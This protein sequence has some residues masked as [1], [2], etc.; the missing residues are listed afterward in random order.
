MEVEA[1]LRAAM[2]GYEGPDW[3]ERAC[4]LIQTHIAMIQRRKEWDC[5]TIG[6]RIR[7]AREIAGMSQEQL[8]LRLDVTQLELSGWERGKRDLPVRKLR[9]LAVSMGVSVEWLL[10]ES[11]EGGPKVKNGLLRRNLPLKL[12]RYMRKKGQINAARA[13]AARINALR[14]KSL[15]EVAALPNNIRRKTKKRSHSRS[16]TK[17]SEEPAP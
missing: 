12:V 2:D 4:E 5:S 8:A 10:M 14:Q 16:R 9:G 11:D 3:L 1:R 7:T 15:T 13:E 6:K 17:K